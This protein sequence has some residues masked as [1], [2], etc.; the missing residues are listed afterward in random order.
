LS[1]LRVGGVVLRG[2]VEEGLA[3]KRGG[4]EAPFTRI[5]V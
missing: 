4:G 5:L 3:S 2:R 1:A